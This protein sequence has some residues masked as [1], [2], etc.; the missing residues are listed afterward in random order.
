[1]DH[2]SVR[3][4][5]RPF[6]VMRGLTDE[7]LDAL[8]ST[9]QPRRIAGGH[10]LFRQGDQGDSLYFLLDGQLVAEMKPQKGGEV[11]VAVM[12]PG[13][14][15]GELSF[16]DPGVRAASVRARTDSTLL[17]WSGTMFNSLEAHAPQAA[18]PVLRQLVMLLA[19]RIR[20]ENRRIAAAL[21]GRGPSPQRARVLEQLAA[22][23][24]HHSR[25]DAERDGTDPRDL[26]FLSAFSPEERE[27]LLAVA[28][29]RQYPARAV[30]WKQGAQ[31]DSCGIVLDGEARA[32]RVLLGAAPAFAVLGKGS[33][34]GHLSLIDG[35]RRSATVIAGEGG[36]RMLELNAEVFDRL[37]RSPSRMGVRFQKQVAVSLTRQLR[38]TN[39]IWSFVAMATDARPSVSLAAPRASTRSA[40]APR[41]LPERPQGRSE[42]ASRSAAHAPDPESARP[43]APAPKKPRSSQAP[44]HMDSPAESAADDDLAALF[45][46]KAASTWGVRLSALD[47]VKVS[48]PDGVM[49]ELEERLRQ[50][51]S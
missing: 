5:L 40:A 7:L 46:K 24:L 35:S 36:V 34:V 42:T 2:A 33:L 1:M 50:K 9:M 21:V 26:G 49:T 16:L 37:L 12:A 41:T 8:I 25:A 15:F 10:T 29:V 20:I 44:V 14:A 27:Q 11:P 32:Q 30:I 28:A 51:G 43:P 45:L 31:G 22:A 3:N 6:P 19:R 47:R 18:A 4:I 17:E 23:P 39:R 13:Q 48:R 38:A